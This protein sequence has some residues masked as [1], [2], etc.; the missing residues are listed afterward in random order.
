MSFW[1]RIVN[2][3]RPGRLSGEIDEEL[4][5]HVEEA[6]AR[7]RDPGE[8]RQALGGKLRLSEKSRDVKLVPWL[9]SLRAD[10]VFGWRQLL[11]KKVT[12]GAA[13]LSLALGMGACTCAFRLVDAL[14]LRP[15]PVSHPERLYA[16]SR[17][18][19]RL[20]ADGKQHAYDGW[21]YLAFRLMRAA[22][23]DQA[24]LIAVSQ[25]RT[26]L[27]F[28]SGQEV[29]KANLQ[30]VSGWMFSTF[31]LQPA[32]GRLFNERDDREPGAHP[33]AVLSYPYWEHRF[34]RDPKVIGSTFRM[35]NR[36][37]EIVGVSSEPFTGTEP[38]AVTDIFVP[39]M[40]NP[41]VERT[42][43]TWHEIL[44]QLKPGVAA[45]PVRQRLNAASLAFETERAKGFT[46]MS[47]KSIDLWLQQKVLLEPAAS[48]RSSWQKAYRTPLAA[49]G[50]LVAL[51]LL[52]ACVN[53]ANLMTAQ[54][55]AR[56]RELALRVSIGAGRWR[57]VQLVLVESAL[58]AALAG[59]AA[60]LFA[61]WSAPFVVSLL[62]GPLDSP[63]QLSLPLDGRVL[64]FGLL[65]TLGVILLFGLVP[66]LRASAVQPAGA[67]RGGDDPHSRRRLMHALVALQV[68]FCFLV[69]FATSLF[70]TTFERLSHQPTGF[71][72]ERLLTLETLAEHAQPAVY[73]D[74]V[75]EHLRSLPGVQAV[76]LCSR[77]LLSGYSSNDAVAVNG[78]PASED[79]AYF[80]NVSPGWVDEM[81][82]PFLAGRDFVAR[83]TYPGTAIVSETFAKRFFDGRNPVGRIFERAGD[84]GSR[85]PLRIVGL[86]RDAR[87][88]G[89]RE[90]AL[91]VA[92]VPFQPLDAHDAI[93]RGTFLVQTAGS[94]P[95]AL[96]A[97]LRREVSKARAEFRVTNLEAQ[98][99]INQQHTFRE[100]LL[101]GLAVFFGFVAMVLAAVGLYGV[102]DYSVLQRRREI[103]IRMAIGAQPAGIARLVTAEVFSMVL[104]GA[105]SGIALGI[106]SVRYVESLIYD[107]KATELD[108][109]AVP[110]L[111]ILAVALLAASPAVI[112]ALRIDPVQ[113]LRSE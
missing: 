24:E 51:V 50:V 89:M 111:A 39:I 106:A 47:Q 110:A 81:K 30:Y 91:P 79:M 84:D 71:S 22:V 75:A 41:A 40:M 31:G 43:S 14:L 83:D 2:V 32:L 3:F 48:G 107:V 65:L 5:A 42:D 62:G 86:V 60:A 80:L 103:G 17:L 36:I 7:G 68:A 92:Y 13:I 70:V 77:P 63:P 53:V 93:R 73:W 33:Y 34:A 96:A 9:D 108:V 56:S 104:A 20:A 109:L 99:A 16:L 58:L 97:V 101:A 69:L 85:L 11:K 35:G 90:P 76:S 105:V 10:T 15:L 87:Y 44:A 66:A 12:S 100:R 95:L 4:E 38:G 18:D 23:K 21:A 52:I 8:A 19:A 102:L 82:I 61:W 6:I 98:T 74:A 25:S 29:E 55:A 88:M 1:S 112:R 67:L 45:E 28:A 57:L 64:G 54:A 59:A 94:N 46:G 49:L 37:Y 113:M 26:D 72:A 27:T 78:G